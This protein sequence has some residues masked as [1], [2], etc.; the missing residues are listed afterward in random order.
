MKLPDG[1]SEETL[2]YIA[3]DD[4]EREKKAQQVLVLKKIFEKDIVA[5]AEF[6]FPHHCT[7]AIPGF[8]KELYKLY[9]DIGKK[10]VAIAAPRGH[11][12]STVTNLIFLSWAIAYQKAH[13]VFIISNTLKQSTLHL[14]ALKSEIAFNGRFQM[15]YG[16]L[17]T[18]KWAS[19]EIELKGQIKIFARGS[20]QQIRG[21]KYLKYRPDL[22]ILD[23]LE[24][25]ELVQSADRRAGLQRWL[26]SEVYPALD[27]ETGRI[28]YI[29]TILHYDS[30][31]M[32]VLSND[33]YQEW[34]KSLYRAIL[35]EDKVLWPE[36]LNYKALMTIKNDAIK[37]GVGHLFYAE[38]QNEPRDS[39]DQ[40]FK[41]EDWRYYDEKD[42][43]GRLLNT[44]TTA[45][46]AV[47]RSKKADYSVIVT[48]SVDSDG[49]QY[50]REI[51]RGRWAPKEIVD[52]MFLANSKWSPSKFGVEDGIEWLTL[53]P[54]VEDEIKRRRVYLPLE[55]LKHGGR[56]KKE[57]PTRIRGLDPLYKTHKMFHPKD[58]EETKL[59]EDELF[60]FP[61]G[62]HDDII[63]ALAYI[64]D[65]SG[66]P[67]ESTHDY[68][69][70]NF[71]AYGI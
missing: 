53:K 48:V 30:L 66:L 70:N 31:L 3:E 41:R 21:L 37:N 55:E 8:H 25:D 26:H 6:V 62:K 44:F 61:S 71:S 23:D 69:E 34:N 33:M 46:L 64:Q 65:I 13:F 19:E 16:N 60:T 56:S 18:D 67:G 28:L 32:K 10:K 22:I 38:Y 51:R 57:S 45:D 11:A 29:G 9:T 1:K 59:L 49:K 58:A 39:E 4:N 40:F 17:K 35:G 7:K 36:H 2:A 14:E 68:E 54:Y 47:S 15:L 52:Q 27:V 5:Y 20:G 50:I 43:D 12:K 24:D 63:D 42:L